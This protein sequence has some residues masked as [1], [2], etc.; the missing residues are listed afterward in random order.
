MTYRWDGG[1]VHYRKHP[2]RKLFYVGY[3]EGLTVVRRDDGTWVQIDPYSKD[4]TVTSY[5]AYLRGGYQQ[6]ITDEHYDEL[7]ASGFGDYI[8]EV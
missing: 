2:N 4:E 7:V 5:S 3:N 6:D 1:P 8:T